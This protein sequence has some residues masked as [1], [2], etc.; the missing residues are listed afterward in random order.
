MPVEHMLFR[1]WIA[2]TFRFVVLQVEKIHALVHHKSHIN[3]GGNSFGA[4]LLPGT[5]KLPHFLS[6]WETIC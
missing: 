1:L 5:K 6:T 3:T 2:I 4:L